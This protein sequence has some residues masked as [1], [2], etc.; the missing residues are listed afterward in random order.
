MERSRLEPAMRTAG[1]GPGALVVTG[2][3]DVGKSALTLRVAEVLQVDGAAVT[4]I[5]LRDL[6]SS[7]SEFEN[8]L[9]GFGL[10]EVLGGSESHSLRLLIVDGAESALEGKALL[11]Q[12]VATEALKA[13]I[14]V[15]AVTRTDGSR[16]VRDVLLRSCE[17]AGVAAAPAEHVIAPLE[18]VC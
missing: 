5:S 2:D 12:V 3:P 10:D 9:G 17:S 13:G 6:P 4:S 7:P 18:R 1:I 11:L 15:V 8:Q 14:G 16:Q